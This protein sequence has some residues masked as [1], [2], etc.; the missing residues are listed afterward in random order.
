MRVLQLHTGYRE[1]GGEDAVVRADRTA[2]ESAGHEVRTHLGQNPPGAAGAVA[3][4]AASPWNLMA[5]HR[6]E[7]AAS[8]FTPDVAHVHN[9][10]FA[11]S[12]AVL[13][14][15]RRHGVPVVMTVHNYRL[16]CSNGMLLRSGLPCERCLDG[17]PF[18]AVRHRCYRDSRTSSAVAATG[19][20]LHR[21][22]GS[23]PRLVDTFIALSEFARSRIVRAGVPRDQIVLGANFVTDPGPRTILPSESR[24]VVFVGRLSPEKGVNVLLKAW[25]QAG[26]DGFRL[27]VIG[28]G[29]ARPGLQRGAPAGVHFLG[30]RSRTDVTSRLLAAR[31]VVI[32][33]V[34]YEGQPL[35]AL[36]GLAAGAPL[37]V[38]DIGGLPE[39]LGDEPAGLTV[40]PGSAVL[41]ASAL[42]RLRED[43]AV[44]RLGAEARRRYRARF[45]PAA[46]VRR[47]EAAYAAAAEGRQR[48]D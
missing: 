13:A 10:W 29:P 2:L 8:D 31:A 44:D 46:G 35:A 23:W 9:T 1:S 11:M 7:R 43:G 37:V 24:D 15:L 14:P 28:D 30:R 27:L 19:I 48:D 47:L 26:M 32:P 6:A 22:L 33:S 17:S 5:A 3:A 12:P 40:P 20:A 21:R 38:S 45:T 16:G 34:W 18:N 25:E 42:E 39:V 36:D 4:L 41:L